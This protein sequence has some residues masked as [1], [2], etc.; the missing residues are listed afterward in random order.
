MLPAPGPPELITA[1][2]AEMMEP[3]VNWQ[4]VA[5]ERMRAAAVSFFMFGW[6]EVGIGCSDSGMESINDLQRCKI[7]ANN[8]Q[9]SLSRFLSVITALLGGYLF[10]ESEAKRKLFRQIHHA[11]ASNPTSRTRL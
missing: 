9:I 11:F 1:D 4:A 2:V 3:A 6:V 8:Y 5:K 10:M 7:H